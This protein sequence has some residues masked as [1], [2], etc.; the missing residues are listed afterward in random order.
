MDTIFDY[1]VDASYKI[2]EFTESDLIGATEIDG[3]FSSFT[4]IHDLKHAYITNNYHADV[5]KNLFCRIFVEMLNE[6]KRLL[7]IEE[8][9]NRKWEHERKCIDFQ[10]VKYAGSMAGY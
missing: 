1:I 3:K 8:T 5:N 10:P 2:E 9:E 7:D 6:R 4:V